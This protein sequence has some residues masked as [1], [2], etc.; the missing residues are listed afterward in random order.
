MKNTD[1]ENVQYIGPQVA[2]LVLEFDVLEAGKKAQ[3]TGPGILQEFF[4]TLT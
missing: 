4:L 2:Q 3:L 1:Y